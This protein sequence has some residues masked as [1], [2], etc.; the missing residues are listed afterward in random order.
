M[1][2]APESLIVVGSG[3]LILNNNNTYTGG[4]TIQGTTLEL[5]QFQAAGTGAITFSAGFTDVL[6]IDLAAFGTLSGSTYTFNNEIDGFASGDTINLAGVAF[7]SNWTFTVGSG[8]AVSFVENGI[9]YVLQFDP[10]KSFNTFLLQ[11]DGNGGTNI[12]RAGPSASADTAAVVVRRNGIASQRE[13]RRP[14]QR[15]RA[16]LCLRAHRQRDQQRLSGRGYGRP[17]ACRAVWR[18]DAER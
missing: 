13:C 4:T 17:G 1:A 6:R 12:V 18:A 3:T 8:H 16:R 5:A 11:S 2:Q 15:C 9:T 7:D 14:R 10:A